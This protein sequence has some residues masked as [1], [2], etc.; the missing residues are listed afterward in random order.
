MN[1]L[2]TKNIIAI[3]IGNVFEWYDYF[4]YSFFSIYL[5]KL[6]FPSINHFNSI[7][8]ITASTGVALLMRPLGGIILGFIADKYSRISAMNLAISIMT[9]GLLLISFTPTYHQIGIFAPIMIIS[10]RLMQGFSTGGEFGASAALLMESALPHKRGLYTSLQTWGQMIGVLLSLLVSL[11]LTTYLSEQQ[12]GNWGWRIPFI[13]G[14]LIAPV[15]IYIRRSMQAG[16]TTSINKFQYYSLNKIIQNNLRPM[17][18]VIG[19]VSG[20]TVEMYTILSY[21]PT[22]VTTYLHLTTHDAYLALL[23]GVVIMTILI[24]F[25]GWISDYI[26]K[27][28]ILLISRTFCLGAILP[29]FLWLNASPS[30]E[31]LIIIQCIF[32][33]SLS[34][35]YG[36]ITAII[37]ELFDFEV[38]ATC[39]SVSFSLSVMIFGAFAQFFVTLLIEYFSNPIAITIYPLIGVA[40]SLFSVILYKEK[41]NI[42]SNGRQLHMEIN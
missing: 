22:Y 29:C 28:P 34:L 5:A 41:L 35:H 10:A 27:K 38:R 13:F 21:M 15:G 3:I 6:F 17:L 16:M 39:L 20:G 37:T 4:V 33:L 32:C 26:G 2:S 14:L 24:P 40:I 42:I 36:A 8:A 23:T 7:L 31:R 11:K 18:I 12:I 19:L 9:I 25:V 30:L 1:Q